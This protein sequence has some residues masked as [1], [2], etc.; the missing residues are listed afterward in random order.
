MLILAIV[1]KIPENAH[2]LQLIFAALKLCERHFKLTLDFSFFMPCFGFCKGC[3]AANPCPLCDQERSK[4][5]G[6]K[7]RW[8]EGEV[9]L[10]SFQSLCQNHQGWVEGGK[11]VQCSSDQEVEECYWRGFDQGGWG[12]RRHA[13]YGQDYPWAPPLVLICQ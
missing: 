2:H 8:V 3:G 12:H 13:H 5:G 11:E 4:V 7:A 9:S 10:R 6:G 1:R